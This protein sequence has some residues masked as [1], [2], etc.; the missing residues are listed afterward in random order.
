MGDEILE[1]LDRRRHF[2]TTGA[3]GDV[4]GPVRRPLVHA[5]HFR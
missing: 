1:L 2:E 3:E 4:T 5:T